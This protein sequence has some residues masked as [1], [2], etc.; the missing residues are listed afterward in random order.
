MFLINDRTDELSKIWLHRLAG[1]ARG[2]STPDSRSVSR[3]FRVVF[4]I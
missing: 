3:S 1:Q 4:L 2:I